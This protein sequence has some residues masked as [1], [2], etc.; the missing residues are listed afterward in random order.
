MPSDGGVRMPLTTALRFH[1]CDNLDA[2]AAQ[3]QM[4]HAAAPCVALMHSVVLDAPQ[5]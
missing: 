1:A 5:A 4:R 2:L 3:A